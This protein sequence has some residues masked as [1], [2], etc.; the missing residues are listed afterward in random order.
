MINYLSCID[1]AAGWSSGPHRTP[2]LSGTDRYDPHHQTKRIVRTG[3]KPSDPAEFCSSRA[4][5]QPSLGKAGTSQVI[6]QERILGSPSLLRAALCLSFFLVDSV[7]CL[8]TVTDPNRHDSWVSHEFCCWVV[9]LGDVVL[10]RPISISCASVVVFW[11]VACSWLCFGMS[12]LSVSLLCHAISD[13][14]SFC[15]MTSIGV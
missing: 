13:A 4:L 5:S 9:E 7:M 14:S 11:F 1:E 10:G 6:P 8:F 15:I 2:F 3:T 12:Y